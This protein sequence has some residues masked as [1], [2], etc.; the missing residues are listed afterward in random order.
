MICVTEVKTP[1]QKLST[2]CMTLM[3]L[4]ICI[5]SRPA[6]LETVRS[7]CFPATPETLIH[8][9]GD[10]PSYACR[11]GAHPTLREQAWDSKNL[12]DANGFRPARPPPN[13][14]A[15]RATRARVGC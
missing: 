5:Q 9:T 14:V 2:T 12:P 3:R 7:D 11:T 13:R 4:F 1:P 8:P 6:M 10:P 15:A